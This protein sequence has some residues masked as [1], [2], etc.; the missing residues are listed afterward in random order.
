[1]VASSKS[2]IPAPQEIRRR[3]LCPT[4]KSSDHG[5][6]RQDL[7][8]RCFKVIFV[9][10]RTIKGKYK[11]TSLL[12]RKLTKLAPKLI[13]GLWFLK[14]IVRKQA[15]REWLMCLQ[16]RLQGHESRSWVEWQ[17]CARPGLLIQR[18][19][20]HS[21]QVKRRRG[22]PHKGNFLQTECG[23]FGVRASPFYTGTVI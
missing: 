7:L 18:R 5:V 19:L 16:T 17:K 13:R 3:A 4:G 6:A 11:Q 8:K 9:S 20:I 2:V 10:T 14:H 15:T 23:W 1:M 12:T 21:E 22:R